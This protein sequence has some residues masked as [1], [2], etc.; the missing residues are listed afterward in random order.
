MRWLCPKDPEKFR[1]GKTKI[2]FR[3]GQVAYLEKLRS[4]K[5]HSACVG[6]QKTVR[7]WLALTKYRKMRRSAATLQR[8]FRG[9]R[10][11]R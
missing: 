9:Y 10:A 2:F 4:D 1:F 8:C 11:R 3:A 6:I 5:L 7:R